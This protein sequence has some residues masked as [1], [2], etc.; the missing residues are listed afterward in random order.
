MRR[1]VCSPLWRPGM[2]GTACRN[3]KKPRLETGVLRIAPEYRINFEFSA[4]CVEHFSG[5]RFRLP[6][7]ME[8]LHTTSVTGKIV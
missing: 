1:E 8:G 2:V 7:P 4:L 3:K 5:K 6:S